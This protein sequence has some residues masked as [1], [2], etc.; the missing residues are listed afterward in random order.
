[1]FLE[2]FTPL[3]KILH[4]LR[5]WREWQIPPLIIAAKS[6]TRR[7]TVESWGQ[8]ASAIRCHVQVVFSCLVLVDAAFDL[9][10]FWHLL[11]WKFVLI[12]RR[13][14]TPSDAEVGAREIY[15]LWYKR[16]LFSTLQRSHKFYIFT[17]RLNLRMAEEL[18]IQGKGASAWPLYAR[19]FK[20]WPPLETE[21]NESWKQIKVLS[22]EF[23]FLPLSRLLNSTRMGPLHSQQRS[24]ETINF[25][26]EPIRTAHYWEEGNSPLEVEDIC[27]IGCFVLRKAL[28]NIAKGT[29]DPGVDCLTSNFGL[30][31]LVQYAW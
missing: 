17:Y 1:M 9:I 30:E 7:P 23:P 31:G 4:S 20:L 10:W 27:S 19:A 24:S 21:H 28:K 2:K 16:F 13:D 25:L 26:L 15:R 12:F 6:P 8:V 14:F 29:T 3:A 18:E 5:E 22:G 11:L